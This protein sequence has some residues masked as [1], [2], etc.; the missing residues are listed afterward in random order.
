MTPEHDAREFARAGPRLGDLLAA[1]PIPVI[2]AVNGFALGGGCE[3]ALACDFIY[4]SETPSSASPRS[5]SGS[6]RASAGPSGCCARR[7][8]PRA[9]AVHE[10]RDDRRPRRCASAWS[11]GCPRPRSC[12]RPRSRPA[13]RSPRWARRRSRR[14]Q[15]TCC[16]AGPTCRWRPRTRSRSRASP[17]CSPTDDQREGMAAFLGKRPAAFT[18][19]ARHVGL[20]AH[21][22]NLTRETPAET[23]PWT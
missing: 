3:V 12:C 17:A 14:G 9:R 16:T 15:G 10:R 8:G 22:H 20:R 5:S 7:P 6:S 19:P 2:A 13:R 4:A 23:R 11:T 18:G 21:R 1:L